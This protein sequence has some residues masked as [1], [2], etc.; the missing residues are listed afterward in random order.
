MAYVLSNAVFAAEQDAPKA[1]RAGFLAR[2]YNALVE[3]RT[4]AAEREIARYRPFLTDTAV[5]LRGVDAKAL[6]FGE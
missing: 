5:A 1:E 6:P 3:S 2:F 4:R